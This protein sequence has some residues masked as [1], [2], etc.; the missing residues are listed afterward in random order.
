MTWITSAFIWAAM[1]LSAVVIV[2]ML[3]HIRDQ[4]AKVRVAPS[5][6]RGREEPEVMPEDE[7][8]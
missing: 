3:M 5:Q 7:Q 8:V 6:S 4:K 2:K 1:I